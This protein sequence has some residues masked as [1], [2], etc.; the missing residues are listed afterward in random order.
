[1]RGRSCLLC[2]QISRYSLPLLFLAASYCFTL[3]NVVYLW[4][5][6]VLPIDIIPAFF[7]QKLLADI[8]VPRVM[9]E[10]AQRAICLAFVYVGLFP[11]NSI[12]SSGGESRYPAEQWMR[13]YFRREAI[14]ET[15]A[16]QNGRLAWDYLRFP[17]WIKVRGVNFREV[18]T[19]RT[20]RH[21]T[22]SV[23]QTY[24]QLLKPQIISC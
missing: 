23:F 3:F 12:S 13:E 1:M 6:F 21:R 5:R 22:W 14:V 11:L 19:G 7:G 17:S 24:I 8:L 20:K 18:T 9:G 16:F 2:A 15:F 4:L 10:A